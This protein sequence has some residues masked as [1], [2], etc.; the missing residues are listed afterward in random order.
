MDSRDNDRKKTP[1]EKAFSAF[2][3]GRRGSLAQAK[4]RSRRSQ[5]RGDLSQERQRRACSRHR[6]EDT[7]NELVLRTPR[8]MPAM[9]L[10][11]SINDPTMGR[12][13][14]KADV[15][16][17]SATCDPEL[18][19]QTVVGVQ[20]ILDQCTQRYTKVKL[21]GGSGVNLINRRLVKRFKLE[22]TPM[23]KQFLMKPAWGS[24]KTAEQCTKLSFRILPCDIEYRVEFIV[25]PENEMFGDMLLG[26]K[27]LC[28]HKIKE[29][30]EIWKAA[31]AEE[32][33]LEVA[34]CL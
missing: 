25:L 19:K 10:P 16:T 5:Q 14:N 12:S 3:F 21:D 11:R 27:F 4:Q 15:I 1:L 32:W 31:V 13:L 23:K 6:F 9:V 24:N 18:E 22:V 8:L 30:G 7:Q 17:I 29:G 26:R 33:G 28:G 34:K 20:V 2:K